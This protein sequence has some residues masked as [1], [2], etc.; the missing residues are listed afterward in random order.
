MEAVDEIGR[1]RK[2]VSDHWSRDLEAIGGKH[3]LCHQKGAKIIRSVALTNSDSQF[4]DMAQINEKSELSGTVSVENVCSVLSLFK[5]RDPE[6]QWGSG[7]SSEDQNLD[8][9]YCCGEKSGRRISFKRSGADEESFSSGKVEGN[10]SSL[11]V[12]AE[13]APCPGTNFPR[14]EE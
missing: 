6:Y 8:K 11:R 14:L 5:V 13:V 2:L 7:R 9:I 1:Y 12:V 3:L 4:F 10:G